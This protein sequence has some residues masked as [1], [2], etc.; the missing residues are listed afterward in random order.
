MLLSRR[1]FG[2]YNARNLAPFRRLLH[3]GGYFDNLDYSTRGKINQLIKSESGMELHRMS[4]N[5]LVSTDCATHAFAYSLGFIAK[6]NHRQLWSSISEMIEKGVPLQPAHC[7]KI[8]TGLIKVDPREAEKFVRDM[9]Q[10]GVPVLFPHCHMIMQAWAKRGDFDGIL[11]V[12]EL[13]R[14][15]EVFEQEG[16]YECY[17]EACKVTKKAPSI[18]SLDDMKE[19][20]G[21]VSQET[22]AT[23][24]EGTI[25]SGEKDA[26]DVFQELQEHGMKM[27]IAPMNVMLGLIQCFKKISSTLEVLKKKNIKPNYKTVHILT[28]KGYILSLQELQKFFEMFEISPAEMIR[29]G[30]LLA[31]MK[32]FEKQD[33]TDALFDTMLFRQNLH[34]S[35][36]SDLE[37]KYIPTYGKPLNSFDVFFLAYLKHDYTTAN[38]IMEEWG[39]SLE[40]LT[41]LARAKGEEWDPEARLA[42]I[43][44]VELERTVLANRRSLSSLIIT[45]AKIAPTS[46]TV[47]GWLNLLSTRKWNTLFKAREKYFFINPRTIQLRFRSPDYI[48]FDLLN[49][50]FEFYILH[51]PHFIPQTEVMNQSS[52]R[53]IT[54]KTASKFFDISVSAHSQKLAISILRGFIEENTTLLDVYNY[55]AKHEHKR[56][57]DQSE[58]ESKSKIENRSQSQEQAQTHTQP[59]PQPQGQLHESPDSVVRQEI[60]MAQDTLLP[61]IQQRNWDSAIDFLIE[62]KVKREKKI[63]DVT[64]NIREALTCNEGHKA[65]EALTSFLQTST[66]VTTEPIPPHD[67]SE[68]KG[69]ENVKEEEEGQVIEQKD[70]HEVPVSWRLPLMVSYGRFTS[71]ELR[72]GDSYLF[73]D[74]RL[75]KYTLQLQKFVHYKGKEYWAIISYD[76]SMEEPEK[77]IIRIASLFGVQK[78]KK[79]EKDKPLF[80]NFPRLRDLLAFSLSTLGVCPTGHIIN[81]SLFFGPVDDVVDL[82]YN[83]DEET[84]VEVVEETNQET[85]TKRESKSREVMENVDIPSPR[86]QTMAAASLN[87][88][89]Q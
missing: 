71:Q 45:M 15:F 80:L 89:Y 50:M 73:G 37:E 10:G 49:S 54:K 22:Y 31:A 79:L 68:I 7:Y 58:S 88:V 67:V 47:W 33:N 82:T 11:R 55:F 32:S 27:S 61:L 9:A 86:S 76:P 51:R 74:K 75:S 43:E 42:D 62:M 3:K 77:D 84:M 20:T 21:S 85:R 64:Q 34:K 24:L 40:R 18:K 87:Y 60:E 4:L 41:K 13:A 30:F 12:Q 83:E 23:F 57:Q 14:E 78:K 66:A 2:A 72:G 5:K 53:V 29:D 17:V 81:A 19:E 52:L 1:I 59:K 44:G 63:E 65:I 6:H 36:I 26:V 46:Y 39:L 16:S 56:Q 70:A 35:R 8:I 69:K 48:S 38:R 25:A 28:G